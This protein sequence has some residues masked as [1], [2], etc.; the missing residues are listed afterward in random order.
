MARAPGL[1]VGLAHLRLQVAGQLG[2]GLA[3]LLA[4]GRKAARRSPW[5]ATRACQTLLP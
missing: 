1:R 2:L 3:R 4:R 5:N